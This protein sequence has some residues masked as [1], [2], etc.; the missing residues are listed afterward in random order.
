MYNWLFIYPIMFIIIKYFI[1]LLR[2][3][4]ENKTSVVSSLEKVSILDG[5]ERLDFRSRVIS[6][7]IADE[8]NQSQV[9]P[10]AVELL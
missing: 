8:M 3:L 6:A 1:Y 4:K 5:D 9:A 2:L 10:G 7:C